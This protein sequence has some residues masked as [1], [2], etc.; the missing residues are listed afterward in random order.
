MRQPIGYWLKEIDRLIEESFGQ[1]LAEEDLTRRHWQV[2]NTVAAGLT[3]PAELD[4]ALEPFL[5]AAAPSVAPVLDDLVARGWMERAGDGTVGLTSV[6][7]RAH[8]AVRERVVANRRTLTEG[9]TAE[10]YANVVNLLERMAGNLRVATT[11]S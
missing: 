6:G 3:R 2:L 10:E 11:G 5:S 7:E 1:L 9:I 8:A 4:A